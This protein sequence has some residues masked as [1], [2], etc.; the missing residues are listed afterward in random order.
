M[1][2]LDNL[3]ELI[4]YKAVM[5]EF[6]YDAERAKTGRGKYSV[7][8]K[9]DVKEHFNPKVNFLVNE[10]K[11]LSESD[12]NVFR[13]GHHLRNEAY[14]NG[15]LR[16]RIMVAVSQTYFQTLC[17]IFPSLWLGS[18]RYSLEGEVRE[19]LNRYGI[20]DGSV[21]KNVL[22]K[23]CLKILE[24]R[25]C[26]EFE[27]AEALSD[28]LVVRLQETLEQLEYLASAPNAKSP[29]E[30]LAWMQFR[31]EG[32]V[33]DRIINSDEE[34]RLFWKTVEAKFAEFRPKVTLD[35]LKIWIKKAEAIKHEKERGIILQNFW[36]IDNQFLK[37]ENLVSEAVFEYEKYIDSQIHH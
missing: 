36:E 27:V 2:L 5:L 9:R 14:H 7:R 24:G 19:F 18:Y 30:M 11:R 26:K 13:V 8:K 31:E 6:A 3:A 25:E 35:T 34:F 12:G 4:M 20:D 1:F 23:I 32:G 37:I 22:G 29:A 33:E 17:T 15:I 10:L 16:E 21:D 28:D